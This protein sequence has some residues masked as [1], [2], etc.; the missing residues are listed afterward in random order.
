VTTTIPKPATPLFMPAPRPTQRLSAEE[1]SK[2]NEV[3]ADLGFARPMS[4]SGAP[5]AL[6]TTKEPNVHLEK[7]SKVGKSETLV[8]I[9]KPKN[10]SSVAAAGAAKAR[11]VEDLFGNAQPLRLDVPQDLWLDLKVSAAKRR[12]SVRWLVLEALEKAG[13][14]VSLNDIPEDGRRVR[15]SF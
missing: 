15:N 6:Q 2:L 8:K 13:Y 11:D 3:S 9:K 10:L 1:A 4:D 7:P 5:P 14:D 12:V